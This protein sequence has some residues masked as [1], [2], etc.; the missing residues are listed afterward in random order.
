[1]KSQAT[2]LWMLAFALIPACSPGTSGDGSGAGSATAGSSGG[3]ESEG[4]SSTSAASAGATTTGLGGSSGSGGSGGPG[5]EVSSGGASSDGCNFVCELDAGDAVDECDVFAQD[6]PMGQKCV[7]AGT[8]RSPGWYLQ[9]C[10]PVSGDDGLGEPCSVMGEFYS[11]QDECGLGF[12]CFG[13]EIFDGG[14][15]ECAAICGGSWE[16]LVCPAGTAIVLNNDVCLCIDDCDPLADECAAGEICVSNWDGVGFVCR[17]VDGPQPAAGSPCSGDLLCANGSTCVDSEFFPHPG[18]VDGLCCAPLC[19]L[20]QGTLDN[21]TC[22]AFV[23]EVPGVVCE[24][25]YAPGEAP[26]G[27][28]SLGACVVP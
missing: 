17:Q 13:P 16:A 18:C 2:V 21:P 15:G 4:M 27:Y 24:P 25:F 8:E 6:C 9:R 22:A 23:G 26:E 1:M 28:A 3:G 7:F 12:Q 10:V 5:G 20:S 11:G 14:Q 19:D